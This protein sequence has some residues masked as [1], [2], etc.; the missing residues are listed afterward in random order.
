[1]IPFLEKNYEDNREEIDDAVKQI[2][3]KLDMQK[4]QIFELMEKLTKRPIFNERFQIRY[5]TCIR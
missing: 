1:L 4:D 5:T 2:K 3:I